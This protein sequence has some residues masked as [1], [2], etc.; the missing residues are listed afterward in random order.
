MCEPC[1]RIQIQSQL[2]NIS[3][4]HNWIFPN[5]ITFW[6]ISELHLKTFASLKCTLHFKWKR[7]KGIKYSKLLSEAKALV[8][9]TCHDIQEKKADIFIIALNRN[10]ENIYTRKPNKRENERMKRGGRNNTVGPIDW[11][12]FHSEPFHKSRLFTRPTKLV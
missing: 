6:P 12:K 7:R 4:S 8:E 11:S 3:L 5:V 9:D 10:N 1:G 2:D